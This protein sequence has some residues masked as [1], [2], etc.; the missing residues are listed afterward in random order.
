MDSQKN[1]IKK[2]FKTPLNLRK[3][4]SKISSD[5]ELTDMP[6][7]LRDKL[8]SPT[9]FDFFNDDDKKINFFETTPEFKLKDGKSKGDLLSQSQFLV[10]EKKPSKGRNMTPNGKINKKNYRS[11]NHID[12]VIR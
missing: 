9:E 11:A 2:I 7:S 4:S 10:E 12:D 5:A 1:R 3:T 6:S 8:E